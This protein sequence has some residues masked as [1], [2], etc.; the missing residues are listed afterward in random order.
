MEHPPASD[1][2]LGTEGAAGNTRPASTQCVVYNHPITGRVY[3]IGGRSYCHEHYARAFQR[4]GTWPTIW[5][6]FAGLIAF[7]LLMQQV[8]PT[9]T[10]LLRGGTLLIV[11]LVM[12]LLPAL[13][14]LFVFRHLDQLEP[15]QLHHLLGVMILG[16]LV[17]VRRTA[18]GALKGGSPG[19]PRRRLSRA[20]SARPSP[21]R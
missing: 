19:P 15:E 12:A 5:I 13:I 8:G 14:W 11:G 17:G 18:R 4:H 16:A 10:P 9:L 2:G 20:A 7:S 6:L 21:P 3:S 1:A